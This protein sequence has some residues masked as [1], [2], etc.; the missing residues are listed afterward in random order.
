[1]WNVI[2]HQDTTKGSYDT[3][4]QE[5]LQVIQARQASC[6]RISVLNHDPVMTYLVEHAGL[7]QSSPYQ[8]GRVSSPTIGPNEC[9]AVVK[10]YHGVIPSRDIDTMY[11]Q[12]AGDEWTRVMAVDIGVDRNAALKGRVG[13]EVFPHAYIHLDVLRAS[14]PTALP[15]WRP[16]GT[17]SRG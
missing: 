15:N 1:M 2:H 6:G 8:E 14:R 13:H 3:D 9:V 11:A 12:V 7:V 17:G 16:F 10:T 5:A 4:Y